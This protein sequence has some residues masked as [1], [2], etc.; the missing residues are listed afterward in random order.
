MTA[1]EFARHSAVP[2]PFSTCIYYK[3]LFESHVMNHKVIELCPSY[4]DKINLGT[5]FPLIKQH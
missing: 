5:N 2:R 1:P 3:Q 4:P